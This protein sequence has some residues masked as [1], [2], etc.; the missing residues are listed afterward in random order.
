M[1][2]EVEKHGFPRLL[3][4]HADVLREHRLAVEAQGLEDMADAIFRAD[5]LSICDY[6]Y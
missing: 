2:I 6:A 5:N 1:Q 4:L 3:P